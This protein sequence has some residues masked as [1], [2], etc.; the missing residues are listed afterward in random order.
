MV[1]FL[2]V[3]TA[4]FTLPFWISW[5]TNEV[6][7]CWYDEPEFAQ[8]SVI[9]MTSTASSTSS[10]GPRK[11]RFN[12]M[13]SDPRPG[14]FPPDQPKTT[15]KGLPDV[16]STLSGARCV[17][18]V[19]RGGQRPDEREVAVTLGV[20]ETVTDDELVADI[21]PGVGDLDLHLRRRRLAQHR[22]YRHRGRITRPQVADKPG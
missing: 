17:P 19:H 4:D 10:S 1:W 21:E 22:A 5:T 18:P 7:F 2:S 14:P 16:T 3:S 12:S 6:S 20:I 15:R 13:A 9:V 11:K 8:P